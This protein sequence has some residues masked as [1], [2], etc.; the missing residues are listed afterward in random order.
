MAD[1]YWNRQQP[2]P[3]MLSSGGMLKRPRTD[4]DA[5][6]SGLHPAHEMH[7]NLAR[8]DDQGGH[9]AVKDTKTIGSAYDRYLQSAQLSSFTSGEASTFG[10]LGRAVGVAMPARPMADPPVMGRPASAAPDLALN[11]GN[12]SFGGQFPID[13]MARLGRD[14][15]PLPPD[16]SNTLFVEGLPPDSTRRE[17]AH[18]FRPFVGYKEVRLVSKEYKHRGGD[19]IILC[20]VDFSSPACAA[21]A[22]SA[23]QGYKIDEHDPDSNYLRLQFSRNPGPRSGSGVRGR[24]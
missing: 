2:T 12:V 23:L 1:N 19:P 20:F 4:Y 7:H 14:I 17:V 5:P 18:I 24:R 8:D 11:G 9:L 15:L 13:P 10:G 16:A 22:M 3:P 21:T 6:P